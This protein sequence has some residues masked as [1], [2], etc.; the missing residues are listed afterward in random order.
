LRKKTRDVLR[1][2]QLKKGERRGG[3]CL[4]NYSRPWERT[5]SHPLSEE[6]NSV[7]KGRRKVGYEG[8]GAFWGMWSSWL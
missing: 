3:E 6:K 5:S 8:D 7:G 2:E 4:C 1:H